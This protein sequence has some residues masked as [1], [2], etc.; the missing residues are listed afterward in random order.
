[1]HDVVII[2]AGV[3][4]LSAAIMLARTRRDSVI[5]SSR[6]RRNSSATTVDNVPYV[7]GLSPHAVYAKMEQGAFR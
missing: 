1:M 3:V 2:G 4:G 7:D 6:E 5:V